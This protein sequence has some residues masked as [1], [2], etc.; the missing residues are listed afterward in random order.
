MNGSIWYT[1]LLLGVPFLVAM[2]LY[3]VLRGQDR[4][5]VSAAVIAIGAGVLVS[6][7][8]SAVLLI[9]SLA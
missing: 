8:I 6:F 3:G 7:A 5:A 4:S 2:A 9:W 1:L